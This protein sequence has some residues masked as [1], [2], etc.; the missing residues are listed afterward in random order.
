M[1]KSDGRGMSC[2]P[3][4]EVGCKDVGSTMKGRRLDCNKML[5]RPRLVRAS[6]IRVTEKK[7]NEPLFDVHRLTGIYW[8]N[9]SQHVVLSHT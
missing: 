1:P 3:C 9:L 6:R 7:Y 2:W 8:R 4:H 5:K